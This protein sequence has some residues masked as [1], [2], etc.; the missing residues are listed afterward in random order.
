MIYEGSRLQRSPFTLRVLALHTTILLS[1]E[2]V[3]NRP[4]WSMEMKSVMRSECRDTAGFKEGREVAM[5]D[6]G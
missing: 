1:M 5:S 4:R 6:E 2:Q 3:A